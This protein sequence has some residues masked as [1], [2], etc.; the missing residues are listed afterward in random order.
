MATDMSGGTPPSV[1]RA[2]RPGTERPRCPHG[3]FAPKR[4]DVPP[5]QHGPYSLY[6]LEH[7]VKTLGRR[8]FPTRGVV[9]RALAAWRAELVADLGGKDMVT[10]QQAAVVDLALKTKLLL[11]SI[12]AWLL[13][14]RSLVNKTTRALWPVV[15]QR[16]QLADALARY[17]NLLG[18]ERRARPVPALADYVANKYSAPAKD[19]GRNDVG[20]NEDVGRNPVGRNDPE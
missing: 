9:G 13:T 1:R 6:S 11:D 17:M 7:V 2:F 10:T 20:R 15:L 16:Q 4:A 18:L 14:Q 5:C 19:V 8:P 12:D 3:F